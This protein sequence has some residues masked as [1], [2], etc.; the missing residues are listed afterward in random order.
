MFAGIFALTVANIR[1]YLDAQ[2]E[3]HAQ[4][5][6][7][8]LGL[9]LSPHLADELLMESMADAVFDRGHSQQFSV[10]GS[11]GQEHLSRALPIK[12]M[13]YPLGLLMPWG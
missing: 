4:D 10:V 7:T 2:H 12:I 9:S 11:A 8:A 13:L 5:G 6:A 3:S 1:L